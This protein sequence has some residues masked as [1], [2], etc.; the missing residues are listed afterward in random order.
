MNLERR[1]INKDEVVD[2]F[3]KLYENTEEYKSGRIYG[4]NS[5]HRLVRE[6]EERGLERG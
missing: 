3:W 4:I 5:T 2:D 6:A 1:E